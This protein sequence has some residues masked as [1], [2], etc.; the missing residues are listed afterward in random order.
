MKKFLQKIFCQKK[1]DENNFDEK[2]WQKIAEKIDKKFLTLKNWWK[3]LTKKFWG[4]IFAEKKF[5]EKFLTK[6]ILMKNFDKKIF[7]E[8]N[9]D[10]K[11]DEKFLT[12]K[13]RWKNFD[14]KYFA[15][16]K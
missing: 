15:K 7:D 2:K 6:K 12:L 13:N 9:F 1:I 14:K 16:K 8:K 10:K 3:N 4:I 5:D 11:I